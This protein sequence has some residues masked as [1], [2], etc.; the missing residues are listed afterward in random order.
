[1]FQTIFNIFLL[2]ISIYLFSMYKV[3]YLRSSILHISNPFK[4]VKKV[5]KGYLGEKKNMLKS[6]I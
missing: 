4:N 3:M 2:D 6:R 5:K 1:M